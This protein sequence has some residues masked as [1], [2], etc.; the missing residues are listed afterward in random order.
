MNRERWY[1]DNGRKID[2]LEAKN[3]FLCAV[4]AEIDRRLV[5]LLDAQ[6]ENCILYGDYCKLR[7]VDGVAVVS[8]LLAGQFLD[9]MYALGKDRPG[10]IEVY[11]DVI[12]KEWSTKS[13]KTDYI[14][15]GWKAFV[16]KEVGDE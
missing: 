15:V 3:L 16:K 4:K 13:E 12:T 7:S 9:C 14:T 5:K 11:V 6:P 10:P 1:D 2:L 8:S